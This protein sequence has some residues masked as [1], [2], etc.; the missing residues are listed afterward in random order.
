[1]KKGYYITAD[2]QKI[3]LKPIPEL[4][5]GGVWARN[6]TEL[7]IPDGVGAVW[8]HNEILTKVTIPKGVKYAYF[9]DNQLTELILPD[10]ID[11]V[12]C[13]NNPHIKE[14]ILPDGITYVDCD[15]GILDITKYKNSSIE[16][17]LFI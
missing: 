12:S 8:C 14:L 9:H 10:G 13:E 7:V 4:M 1:M 15:L 17:I 2:G 3:D 16:I 11:G 5:L 6:I